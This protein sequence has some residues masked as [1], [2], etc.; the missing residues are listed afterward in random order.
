MSRFAAVMLEFPSAVRRL[1]TAASESLAAAHAERAAVRR[2]RMEA[3]SV[4]ADPPA[5]ELKMPEE[6]RE[7]EITRKICHV[8][9]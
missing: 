4:P 3:Q 2:G 6:W 8:K 1:N 5:E 9:G 7:D